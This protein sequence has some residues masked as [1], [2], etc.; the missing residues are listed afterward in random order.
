MYVLEITTTRENL[1]QTRNVKEMFVYGEVIDVLEETYKE[2]GKINEIDDLRSE[3]NEFISS[4]K[5]EKTEIIPIYELWKTSTLDKINRKIIN[6]E[7]A[8]LLKPKVSN[9]ATI[10]LLLSNKLSDEKVDS[11]MFIS[12]NLINIRRFLYL[13][14][15]EIE[16]KNN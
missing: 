12:N 13:I 6:Y 16:C 8:Y 11:K 2:Y 7:K 14:V 4:H 9:S 15:S 1:L 10:Y 5:L 3:F